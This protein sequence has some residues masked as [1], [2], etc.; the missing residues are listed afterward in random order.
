[1]HVCMGMSVCMFFCKYMCMTVYASACI[2]VCMLM[3]IYVCMCVCICVY[4]NGVVQW[5]VDASSVAASGCH[6]WLAL[7]GERVSK[8]CK[9][10]LAST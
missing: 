2:D 1:M 10:H 9:S 3:Y 8:M 4:M 5:L 7:L 6:R